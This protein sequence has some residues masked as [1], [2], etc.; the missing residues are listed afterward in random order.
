L[1][2]KE[3]CGLDKK[4][5]EQES[6]Q[7]SMEE[8]LGKCLRQMEKGL[9]ANERKNT[10]LTVQRKNREEKLERRKSHCLSFTKIQN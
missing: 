8:K 10:Y 1:A 3:S 5:T 7:S 4:S 6:P 9:E 2:E